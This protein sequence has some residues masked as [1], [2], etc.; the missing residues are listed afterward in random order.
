[1]FNLIAF[2]SSLIIVA[3]FETEVSLGEIDSGFNEAES[4]HFFEESLTDLEATPI[5][6]LTA[7]EMFRA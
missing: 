1:M 3:F 5:G 4:S 2:L 6:F 7:F